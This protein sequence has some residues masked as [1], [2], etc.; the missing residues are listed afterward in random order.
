MGFVVALCLAS[1][2]CS[3]AAAGPTTS[4]APVGPRGSATSTTSTS[5]TT[6]TTL[7]VPVGVFGTNTG[8]SDSF[9]GRAER[10]KVVAVPEGLSSVPFPAAGTAAYHEVERLGFRQF[11][12]GPDLLLIGGVDGSMTSWDPTFLSLLARHYRVTLIDLPGTG[13][14]SPVGSAPSLAGVADLVAGLIW[15]LQLV[16][17]AVLGWGLGGDVA[18]ALAAR[19][20]K[21]IS[22]LVLVETPDLGP[23]E[24]LP[25]PEVRR[26]LSAS[27]ANP[28]SLSRLYFSAR[29]TA[30]RDSFLTGIADVLP[31]SLTAQG[32]AVLFGLQR[33]AA[34]PGA[35]DLLNSIK[36]PVLLVAG[37]RDRVVP[38]ANTARLASAL[39]GSK[40]LHIA[41]GDYGVLFEHETETV[42]AIE[43]FIG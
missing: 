42:T 13:Y 21:S 20:P 11:G 25:A 38:P 7:P 16:T 12:S 24:V 37:D 10:V 33:Q 36:A 26:L 30:A 31:D 40:V 35:A 8:G 27:W 34:E 41:G 22:S 28:V 14:S 23:F 19:H 29:Y 9:L 6:T 1:G 18:L 3:S 4:T 32:R 5:T 17:P 39:P 15:S 2:G 43:T